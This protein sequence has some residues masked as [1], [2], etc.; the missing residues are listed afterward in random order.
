MGVLS[1]KYGRMACVEGGIALSILATLGAVLSNDYW[2]LNACVLA[3]SFA[4]VG[5][6]NALCTLGK[7]VV[8]D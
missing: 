4:Q 2:L 3:M 7:C 5:V 8:G 1:D 6:A